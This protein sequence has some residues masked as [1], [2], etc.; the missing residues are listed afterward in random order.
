MWKCTKC[1]E[2]VED[3]YDACWKCSTPDDGASPR[4]PESV[5]P[6]VPNPHSTNSSTAASAIIQR[7]SHAYL[8]ARTITNIGVLIKR[9]ACF[10][11]ITIMLISIS[12]LTQSHSSNAIEA[13]IGLVVAFVTATPIYIL[14]IL[15]AAQGEILKATLDTAVTTSPFINKEEMAKVMSI[16]P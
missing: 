11:G 7:Y 10:I 4:K 6:A 12:Y 16:E 5:T 8:T 15:V 9:T 3:L 13:L 2:W 14:G 1:G